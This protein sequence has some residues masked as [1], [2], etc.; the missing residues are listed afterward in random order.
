[1]KSITGY[2][3]LMYNKFLSYCRSIAVNTKCSISLFKNH[4]YKFALPFKR[5]KVFDE[6][7]EV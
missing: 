1:M 6:I 4:V 2:C 3:V 5:M 7:L